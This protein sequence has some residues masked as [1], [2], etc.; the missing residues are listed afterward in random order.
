MGK[1]D[2]LKLLQQEKSFYQ[3]K[4]HISKLGVFGSFARGENH[5]DSDV[6][7][8]YSLEEGEKIS[9]DSYLDLVSDLEQKLNQK[10]DLVREDK[11]NPLVKLTA[12]KDLIYV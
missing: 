7:I 12:Q 3:K 9:F 6:D 5:K 11:L 2:I 10:I 1:Q 4:Y 8:L